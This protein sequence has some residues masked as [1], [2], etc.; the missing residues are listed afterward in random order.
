MFSVSEILLMNMKLFLNF[1][2]QINAFL[3]RSEKCKFNWK[4]VDIIKA[5]PSI[6]Q[7]S[8]YINK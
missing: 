2:L 3:I 1:C 5:L 6:L 4:E 7:Q 8:I